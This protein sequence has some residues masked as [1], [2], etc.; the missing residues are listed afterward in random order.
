MILRRLCMLAVAGAQLF[1]A[2]LPAQ[3]AP[4]A[5]DL[6]TQ[7]AD[8]TSEVPVV[9]PVRIT[10]APPELAGRFVV[11]VFDSK[12]F[13]VRTL[14][15]DQDKSVFDIGLNGFITS[16]DGKLA[17]GTAAAPGRYSVRG[18][19]VGGVEVEGVAFHFNDWV[20]DGFADWQVVADVML[21]APDRLVAV[22]AA[23]SIWTIVAA[24][25]NGKNVWRVP[26][27]EDVDTAPVVQADADWVVAKSG[28]AIRVFSTADG[29]Q[30]ATIPS[31][32][33]DLISVNRGRL[34]VADG[35][36]VAGFQLPEG[37]P[38]HDWTVPSKILHIA[39]LENEVAVILENKPSEILWTSQ[40][41]IRR[42]DLEGSGSLDTLAAGADA[43]SVWVAGE[44][45]ETVTVREVNLEEGV[46]RELKVAPGDPA[47]VRISASG[48]RLGL[49]FAWDRSTRW[50]CLEREATA[51]ESTSE[52]PATVD[53]TI[54]ANRQI[55]DSARFGISPDGLVAAGDGDGLPDDVTVKLLPNPL[56]PDH[57]DKL[58]V[59]ARSEDGQVWLA[60][61]NGLK[62]LPVSEPDGWT[63]VAL[64]TE[65]DSDEVTLYQGNGW[66]VEEFQITGLNQIASF[67]GGT[68]LLGAPPMPNSPE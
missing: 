26:L 54:I 68:F 17:D 8:D 51:T 11:G 12:G 50:T 27:G 30:V 28:D 64:I 65:A 57:P 52:N 5:E 13:L 36:N 14:M 47:P 37:K 3:N 49:L 2:N 59:V 31:V 42:V 39:A 22:V 35:Q 15:T 4:S 23:D 44:N 43:A 48:S 34:Y 55:V 61:D 67:D 19:V 66:V 38:I 18:Y 32:A 53:W 1:A 40:D 24:S 41:S 46:I 56:N 45:G 63:R 60:A 21:V 25:P 20:A 58:V 16:W 29:S 7:T 6:S 9:P 62:L 10:F 33:S